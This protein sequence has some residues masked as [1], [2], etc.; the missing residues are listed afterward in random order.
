MP[1]YFFLKLIFSNSYK[2]V[3]ELGLNTLMP[4]VQTQLSEDSQPYSFGYIYG[5][6]RCFPIP[7]YLEKEGR[8]E[9][10]MRIPNF[11]IFTELIHQ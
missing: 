2:S 1:Y 8:K 7:Q 5:Y 3:I 11:L 10:R 6:N 9:V 4:S